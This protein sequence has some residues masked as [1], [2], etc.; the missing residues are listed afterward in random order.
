[1]ISAALWVNLQ[2]LSQSSPRGSNACKQQVLLG[3]GTSGALPVS[4]IGV[5]PA[6]IEQVPVS[7]TLLRTGVE[8]VEN[9]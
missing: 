3:W 9:R 2:E 4:A 8:R 7:L 5:G 1:M 6:K